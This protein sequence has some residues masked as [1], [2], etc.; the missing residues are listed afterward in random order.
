ME[1]NEDSDEAA[2]R[3]YLRVRRDV[4]RHSQTVHDVRAF[5]RRQ[6]GLRRSTA[7]KARVAV[8]KAPRVWLPEV[9]ELFLKQSCR[10]ALMPSEVALELL[11]LSSCLPWLLGL[12]FVDTAQ[13]MRAFSPGF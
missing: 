1:H 8:A 9:D 6:E 2:T 12:G 5:S 10:V 7:V 3:E 11:A 4:K 13:K